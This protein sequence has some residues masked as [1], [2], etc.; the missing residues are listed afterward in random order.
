MLD[1][2]SNEIRRP[3]G[4]DLLWYIQQCDLDSLKTVLIKMPHE[5]RPHLDDML[6]Q[7]CVRGSLEVLEWLVVHMKVQRTD[8]F[9]DDSPIYWA[10]LAGQNDVVKWLSL[11]F[12]FTEEEK[13][14]LL[15]PALE[16]AFLGRRPDM[17]AWILAFVNAA[18]DSC[19]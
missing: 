16:W 12:N 7:A 6:I 15:K 17:A 1:D 13:R 4:L 19:T 18:R 5:V 2:A 14:S 8:I 9:V 10:C 11:Y 3:I